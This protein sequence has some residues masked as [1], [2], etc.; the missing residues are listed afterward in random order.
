LVERLNKRRKIFFSL[1]Y[2]FPAPPTPK[3]L[4]L[5]FA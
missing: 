1:L 5:I 3:K 2:S 4:V